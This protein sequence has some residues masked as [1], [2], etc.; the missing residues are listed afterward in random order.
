MTFSKDLSDLDN[1]STASRK[2]TAMN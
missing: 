1:V 2:V